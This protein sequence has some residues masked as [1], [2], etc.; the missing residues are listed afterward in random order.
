MSQQ[1]VCAG[2]TWTERKKVHNIT[3]KKINGRVLV[4]AGANGT[5][6]DEIVDFSQTAEEIG[7]N[8]I[9]LMPPYYW[10]PTD[11]TVLEFYEKWQ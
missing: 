4:I 5:N 10:C 2:M 8:G 1:G 11:K 9:M 6:I 7:A 3:I